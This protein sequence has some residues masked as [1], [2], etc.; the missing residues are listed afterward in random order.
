MSSRS[1]DIDRPLAVSFER[2]GIV[3]ESDGSPSEA[4]GVLNPGITRDRDGCILMYPRAVASGNVSRIGLARGTELSGGIAFARIGFVLEPEMDYEIRLEPGGHGC[5]D[6]RV[7]FIPLLDRYVM[8]YT[9]FGLRGPRVAIALSDDA[10]SWTRLGLMRFSEEAL[11]ALD[12]KDAAFF[13]DPVY[14]P[15]GVLSFAAYHRPMLPFS[16]NGQAPVSTILELDAADRESMWIGYMPVE[17]VV[18]DIGAL[19]HAVENRKILH[20]GSQWG[21]LK[22]GAGTPPV[23]T[24]D[25]WISIFHAVDAVG[26]VGHE[27]RSYS[28]GIVMHDLRSPH[29]ILYR[30]PQALFGPEMVEERIGIVDDVVFPSGLDPLN[31]GTFDIYY[32][33][34]DFKIARGRLRIVE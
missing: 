22:N 28:A 2:L 33:A 24:Q 30:S 25:G 15:A 10:Y 5:E 34:A 13:P 3:L 23:R 32:G 29:K 8:T 11:N 4:E 27:S 18:A 26:E 1:E 6:A 12:N 7:T 17:K 9:A 31:D 14:S 21:T 16:V 19:A 20:V